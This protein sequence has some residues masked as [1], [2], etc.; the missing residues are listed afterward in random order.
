MAIHILSNITRSKDNQTM[1]LGQVIEYGKELFFFRNITENQAA[2][3]VRDFFFF[4]KKA[5]Y[6]VKASGLQPSFNIFRQSSTWHAKKTNFIKLWTINLKIMLNFDFFQKSL[7][8]VSP[9]HFMYA[10]LKKCFSYYI[11]LSLFV[12]F[13][14]LSYCFE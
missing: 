8:I 1:K 14:P 11:L 7:G 6:Q 3:L 13:K 12:T 5:I 2:R 9:T 10:F 4:L